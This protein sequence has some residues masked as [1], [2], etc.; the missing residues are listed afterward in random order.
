M[1]RASRAA[2]PLLAAALA[3]CAST[4]PEQDPVQIKL[5]D[6]EARVARLE[7]SIA[8]EVT[9]SQ[10]LDETQERVREKACSTGLN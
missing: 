8:N 10:H 9:M 7:R 2:L 3:G 5:N 6:L 4:P 1:S